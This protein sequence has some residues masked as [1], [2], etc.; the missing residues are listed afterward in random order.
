MPVAESPS[1]HGYD[2]TD[3]RTIEADYGTLADLQAM[4]AAAHERGIAVI[5]DLVLNHT[6]DRHPWFVDARTPGSVHDDWYVWS[7]TNPGYGGPDGQQVWHPAGDRW[8]YGVF[9]AGLPDLNLANPAVTAELEDVARYWLTDVGV[10]GFRLDAIKHLVEDGTTQVH[11][12][13]TH[14]WL[15]GFRASIEAIEPDALL[16]GEVYDL[17]VAVAHYVPEDVDLAFDFGLAQATL[18]SIGRGNA[19][20][21]VSAGEEDSRLFGPDETATF[22]TN[23]DQERV[24]S[25]LRE[26][27]AALRLAAGLLLTGPG[28]PFLY[29]GEE[30]G[31]TGEKPDEDIRTPMAWDGLSPAAGFSSGTPWEPLADGWETRNVAAQKDDAGSVLATYRELV[32]LRGEHVALAMGDSA[33]VDG[34]VAPVSATLRWTAGE[35]LLDVANV[36]DAQVDD[37]RLTL[38]TG[39][40]CG[41][42]RATFVDGV[43]PVASEFDVAV[44][45]P[46]VSATGGFDAY[47]PLPFLPPR[48][49]TVIAIQP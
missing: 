34:G 9:G 46:R 1:Y 7:A 37:Y 38:A 17:S 13:E 39:P 40:L 42:P 25:Q 10:D 30:I 21:L 23:H 12:P 18:D 48:S 32:R 24:A 5:T 14:A 15:E 11:T 4:I 2:V 49:V 8:Y 27:P 26:D 3:E 35:T 41:S 33:V 19:G 22:L 28:I 6:S 43:F 16:V 20:P 44:A 36:S 31:L 47:R 29:Y 45:A